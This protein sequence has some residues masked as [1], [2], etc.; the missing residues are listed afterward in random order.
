ML[1]FGGRD[2]LVSNLRAG[3]L[4]NLVIDLNSAITEQE[5]RGAID[6]W[7][8]GEFGRKGIRFSGLLITEKRLNLY[9]SLEFPKTQI[10]QGQIVNGILTSLASYE[11][12]VNWDESGGET[13]YPP[14]VDPW[15][16]VGWL[17]SLDELIGKIGN[18]FQERP[19]LVPVIIGATAITMTYLISRKLPKL[20]KAREA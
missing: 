15:K 5:Y 1:V 6:I 11:A 16:E 7:N 13:T 8:R 12:S 17:T 19:W 10:T 2:F 18:Y 20:P 9:Y 14:L 3:V 4:Y